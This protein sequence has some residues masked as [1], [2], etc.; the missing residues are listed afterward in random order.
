MAKPLIVNVIELLRRPGNAKDVSVTVSSDDLEFGDSRMADEDVSV[1][2]HLESMSNGISVHGSASA[3][4]EGECR[5][6]LDPLRRAFTVDLDELYQAVPD[7]PDA[8]II[9]NDQIDLL[10]MVREN[11]LLAIPVGPLCSD[12]C[13]GFCP[14]CG[15]DLRQGGCGCDQV[16]TDD[17]WAALDALRDRLPG[18]PE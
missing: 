2:V 5:R 11:L 15:A 12:D 18:P 4:W 9:E 13:P 16:R 3:A 1:T 10:P 17:R 14:Q 8:H 6:C 7:N